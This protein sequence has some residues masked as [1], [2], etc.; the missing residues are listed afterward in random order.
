MSYYATVSMLYTVGLWD[1][2]LYCQDMYEQEKLKCMSSYRKPKKKLFREHSAL[3][4]TRATQLSE[5]LDGQTSEVGCTYT[6]L[7]NAVLCGIVSS[8]SCA[9]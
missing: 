7:T 3:Y 6:M 4:I 1:V 5:R 2:D 9:V 8:S